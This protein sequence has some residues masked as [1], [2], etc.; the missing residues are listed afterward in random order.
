MPQKSLEHSVAK[1]GKF[2]TSSSTVSLSRS[3]S[4]Q[5]ER[6]FSIKQGETIVSPF[7]LERIAWTYGSNRSTSACATKDGNLSRCLYDWTSRGC[8]FPGC[9]CVCVGLHDCI[10][11][12]CLSLG[13]FRVMTNRSVARAKCGWPHR[14][15]ATNELHAAASS[16]RCRLSA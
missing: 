9:Q 15:L 6:K 1:H 5:S 13:F 11:S 10:Q 12:I 8:Q 2:E 4:E 14:W 3:P 16:R 7:L